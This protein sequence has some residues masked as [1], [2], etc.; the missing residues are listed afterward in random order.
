V[1]VAN[2][3]VA[4]SRTVGEVQEGSGVA[5][6][7]GTAKRGVYQWRY[8]YEGRTIEGAFSFRGN[9]DV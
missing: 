5:D 9:R 2:H 3:A 4:L 8:R 6:T 1:E 7:A